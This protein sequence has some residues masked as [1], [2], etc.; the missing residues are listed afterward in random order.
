MKTTFNR[1]FYFIEI[2]PRKVMNCLFNLELAI[3]YFSHDTGF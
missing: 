3:D 1:G 2:R